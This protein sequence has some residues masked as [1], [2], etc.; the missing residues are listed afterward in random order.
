MPPASAR[1]DAFV[2]RPDLRYAADR[3]DWR[4]VI[5]A[6]MPFTDVGS[7]A[8]VAGV[9]AAGAGAAAGAAAARAAAAAAR[10]CGGP[11]SEGRGRGRGWVGVC[12]DAWGRGRGRDTLNLLGI[13]I[14]EAGVK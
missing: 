10:R 6:L 9:N 5:M 12:W 11:L 4:D 13:Y 3:F 1:L 8:G 14:A 7:A 2:G